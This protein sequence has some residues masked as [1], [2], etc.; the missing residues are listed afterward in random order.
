[1]DHETP[2][3]KARSER[4][5]YRIDYQSTVAGP[6]SFAPVQEAGGMLPSHAVYQRLDTRTSRCDHPLI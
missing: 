4:S 1:M 3:F 2:V 5:N 6:T